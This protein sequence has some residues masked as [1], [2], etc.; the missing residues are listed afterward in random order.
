MTKSNSKK[1]IS[2]ILKGYQSAG[3]DRNGNPAHIVIIE[4]NNR[5]ELYYAYGGFAYS[6]IFCMHEKDVLNKNIWILVNYSK[7]P[8]RS[9]LYIRDIEGI[10]LEK[11][12]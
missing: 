9:K 8:A 7:D 2:G 1:W 10:S 5:S 11:K 4:R 12:D 3:C 6:L